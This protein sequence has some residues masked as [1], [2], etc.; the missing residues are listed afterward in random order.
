[1]EYGLL[2]IVH[3]GCYWGISSSSSNSD[4]DAHAGHFSIVRRLFFGASAIHLDMRFDRTA[5]I[6]SEFF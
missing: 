6:A 3:F 4:V 2:D 5:S 1:M